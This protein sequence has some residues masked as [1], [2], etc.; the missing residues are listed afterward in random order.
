MRAHSSFLCQ[1]TITVNFFTD[2]TTPRK[3]S[4]TIRE[5][6]SNVR[7]PNNVECL[8]IQSDVLWTLINFLLHI[9]QI[10]GTNLP[11]IQ[12]FSETKAATDEWLAKL[13]SKYG[14]STLQ[15]SSLLAYQGEITDL[16]ND[17]AVCVP[18]SPLESP[19]QLSH[20]SYGRVELQI[21]DK[22]V[23]FKFYC[24]PSDTEQSASIPLETRIAWLESC[25]DETLCYQ[26]ITGFQAIA[27]NY[28]FN[29]TSLEE[30]TGDW[31][32]YKQ[33]LELWA[34]RHSSEVKLIIVGYPD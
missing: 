16:P 12:D 9:E 6:A 34:E 17:V 25:L 32:R 20:I 5:I 30:S 1:C 15:K 24:L 29:E 3:K 21:T 4:E 11:K 19:G 18:M 2:M 10:P 27:L 23:F 8:A 26:H 7:H 13:N 14:P 28:R 31:Q 22:L 33:I